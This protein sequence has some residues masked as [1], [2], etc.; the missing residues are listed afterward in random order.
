[1]FPELN[2]TD[3]ELTFKN[4]IAERSSCDQFEEES[5]WQ[6]TK[7]M[8]FQNGFNLRGLFEGLFLFIKLF[9]FELLL[10]IIIKKLEDKVILGAA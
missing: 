5:L 7:N 2:K 8:F 6:K 3:N 10:R 1:M 9:K 4:E